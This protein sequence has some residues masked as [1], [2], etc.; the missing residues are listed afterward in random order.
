[1]LL[2]CGGS[3][4]AEL[5]IRTLL[6]DG[7]HTRVPDGHCRTVLHILGY[8]SL[9]RDPIDTGLLELLVALGI[10]IN[11]ADQNGNTA[12]MCMAISL[13]RISTTRFLLDHGAD[14]LKNNEIPDIVTEAIK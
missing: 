13:C 8:S 3:Q 9:G 7:A 2:G 14:I 5:A 1:M 4:H 10:K 12:M 11:D 6:E